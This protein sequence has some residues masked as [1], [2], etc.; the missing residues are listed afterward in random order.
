GFTRTMIDLGETTNLT[1]EDAATNIAQISN[2]M[3]TMGR[4]GSEG[5]ARMGAALVALGNDGA[6]T[7]AQIL[8]MAQRL[9]GAGAL[10]GLAESDILGIANAA[11][12][13]GIEVEAGGSAISRVFTEMAKATAQ[14]GEDLEA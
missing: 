1:A 8:S 13:M 2:V 6:S 5:V 4:E 10:I 12:S 9:S 3:G 7:E 11:A 14:G